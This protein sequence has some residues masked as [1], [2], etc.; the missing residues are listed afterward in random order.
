MVNDKRASR[1]IEWLIKALY[2]ETIERRSSC[3]KWG[4]LDF[5]KII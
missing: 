4:R 1:M 2:L 5:Y 3:Q